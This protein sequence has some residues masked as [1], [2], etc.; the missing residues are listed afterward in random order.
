MTMNNFRKIAGTIDTRVRQLENSGVNGSELLHRMIGHL[1]D[2]QN[3]WVNTSDRQLATLCEDFP[4]FYT[5]ASLME[6]AAEAERANPVRPAYKDLPQ[7]SDALKAQ[8]AQLLTDAATLERGYQTLIDSRRGKDTS[9]LNKL[10]ELHRKWL[11]DR[12]QFTDALKKQGLPKAASDYA[13][14]IFSKMADRIDSL[15]ETASS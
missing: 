11:A 14:P 6:E 9:Q 4:G 3:I 10:N 15:K 2:L 1:P 13:E 12:K 8:V 7:L 5:Y